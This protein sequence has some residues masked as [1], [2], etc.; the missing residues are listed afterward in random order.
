[1]LAGPA[2]LATLKPRQSMITSIEMQGLRGIR[3]GEITGLAPV[4]VLIGPNGCG[5][6]TVLEALG[7]ACAGS[8]ASAA[9]DALSKREWLGVAG[10][11]YWFDARPNFHVRT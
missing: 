8:S 11:Q 6:S 10:M 3:S 9:F 7:V 5:K 1:M 4:T 2:D